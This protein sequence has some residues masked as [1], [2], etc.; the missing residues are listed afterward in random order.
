MGKRGRFG[1]GAFGK[2]ASADDLFD[3]DDKDLAVFT[4]G[5]SKM[6]SA[7]GIGKRGGNKFRSASMG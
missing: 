3:T 6:F 2:R 4:R 5:G 7:G 1:S